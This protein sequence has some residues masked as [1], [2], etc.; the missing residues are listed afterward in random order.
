LPTD[1]DCI[2]KIAIWSK[3]RHV[4]AANADAAVLY[5]G[6][7]DSVQGKRGEGNKDVQTP[8]LS[9]KIVESKRRN[10]MHESQTATNPNEQKN[11]HGCQH[12]ILDLTASLQ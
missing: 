9:R 10:Q 4:T 2:V 6:R 5:D 7:E 12:P 11:E 8:P 1:C 3:K